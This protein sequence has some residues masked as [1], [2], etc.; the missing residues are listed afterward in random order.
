MKSV[1]FYRIKR[2]SRVKIEEGREK[3]QI[4]RGRKG[5]GGRWRERADQGRERENKSRKGREGKK[6]QRRDIESLRV[7]RADRRG[8][9]ERADRREKEGETEEDVPVGDLA[10]ALSFSSFPF[11]SFFFFF[12]LLFSS[13]RHNKRCA[14]LAEVALTGSWR[15]GIDNLLKWP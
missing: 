15:R 12:N 4:G 3:E 2:G 9:G 5:K 1:I 7:D 11:F 13:L 6:G 10:V 8:G 14:R